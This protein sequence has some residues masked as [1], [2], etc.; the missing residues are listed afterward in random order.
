MI[1]IAGM[2]IPMAVANEADT[3]ILSGRHPFTDVS[4]L[5]VSYQEA[6]QFVW[7]NDV[8]TGVSATRFDPQG[9]FTRAQVAAVLF[10]IHTGRQANNND[11]RN[12]NFNDVQSNQWHAAY[13]TWANRS[14][15]VLGTSPTTFNPEGRI[16][17]QEL[18]TMLLRFA[19]FAGYP[20]SVSGNF[21][22][23]QFSDRNQIASWAL[24]SLRWAVYNGIKTSVGANTLAPGAPMTRAEN[25]LTLWRFM[26]V[27]N[28]NGGDQTQRIDIR[29]LVGMRY[30]EVMVQYGHLWERYSYEID[31]DGSLAFYFP[32]VGLV[33][34]TLPNGDEIDH[35]SVNFD[36][37]QSD[38]FHIG[39]IDHRSTRN[40]VVRIFGAPDDSFVGVWGRIYE[41]VRDQY[42]IL[43]RMD[44]NTDRVLGLYYW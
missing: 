36:Q 43:F 15:I 35:V 4:G 19:N 7:Q 13:V 44:A 20:T 39:G 6:I 10:R 16:T 11:S 32:D 9:N 14:G 31:E 24:E 38:F 5:P 33:I 40:D 28:I 21:N 41:Y 29:D 26:E 12:N 1:L 18:T 34:V 42:S 23:N 30:Y 27:F 25:A 2:L 17:R 3:E 8:M 22:L 37:V